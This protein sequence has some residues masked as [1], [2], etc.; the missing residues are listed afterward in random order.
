MPQIGQGWALSPV[1]CGC[2]GQAQAPP[3]PPAPAVED[4][5]RS[6]PIAPSRKHTKRTLGSVI[7]SFWFVRILQY[8]LKSLCVLPR[9]RSRAKGAGLLLSLSQAWAFWALGFG[10]VFTGTCSL[11]ITTRGAWPRRKLLSMPS[12]G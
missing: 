6:Q 11:P 4:E 9:A 7:C 10:F 12:R 2:M 1:T 3:A 5:D 8:R